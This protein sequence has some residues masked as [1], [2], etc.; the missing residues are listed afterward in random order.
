M[1]VAQL[2][3]LLTGP[4]RS[5]DRL[6]T[7]PIGVPVPPEGAGPG[8]RRMVPGTV[9]EEPGPASGSSSLATPR[10]SP[11][12]SFTAPPRDLAVSTAGKGALAMEPLEQNKTATELPALSPLES[13]LPTPSASGT[14]GN[15]V[16]AASR[17][18]VKQGQTSEFVTK[19]NE[20]INV[21]PPRLL[22]EKGEAAALGSALLMDAIARAFADS[23]TG[24][25][26]QEAQ[27]SVDQLTPQIVRQLEMKPDI[28]AIITVA[29]SQR[30]P[31]LFGVDPEG[32]RVFL[33]ASFDLVR[34]QTLI[35]AKRNFDTLYP[36]PGEGELRDYRYQWFPPSTSTESP[37]SWHSVQYNQ[38]KPWY[39]RLHEWLQGYQD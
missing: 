24:Q 11:E 29:Y 30:I 27:H 20:A 18:S 12:H 35:D 17:S 7:G 3:P 39:R 1:R 36:E 22:S 14:K 9:P 31:D 19:A 10:S 33:W 34:G 37:Q 15:P 32:P 16:A 28:G 8:D 21:S 23:V 2:Y 26:T 13:R 6:L 38:S 5:P 25:Q 4:V